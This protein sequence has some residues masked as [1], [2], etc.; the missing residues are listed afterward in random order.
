MKT[1]LIIGSTAMYHWFPDGRKPNDIDILTKANIKSSS[2]KDCFI[3][4]QWNEVSQLIL[5]TNKDPVFL[6][7]DLLYTLKL[8]HAQ[9]DIKWKKTMSDIVFLEYHDCEVDK[10]IYDELVKV[11]KKIHCSKNVNLNQPV[12]EFFK[13]AV[14]R[15]YD[16]ELL[17]ELVKFNDKPMHEYIRKE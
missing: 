3:D 12:T 7:P 17:H 14:I 5:D 11:W 4:T 9:Y 10:E 15:K 13:D 6:D 1:W 2:L 16:H 8:S